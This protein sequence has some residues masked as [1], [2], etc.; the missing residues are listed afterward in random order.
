MCRNRQ[1]ALL[2]LAGTVAMI[3]L[4]VACA[5]PPQ[6]RDLNEDAVTFVS[7]GNLNEEE[8]AMMAAEAERACRTH[9]RVPVQVTPAYAGSC[10]TPV[11]GGLFGLL[12]PGCKDDI[13][14]HV[15]ACVLPE[16]NEN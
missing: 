11:D 6:L 10:E 9:G 7:Q 14:R 1:R 15:F 12:G 5:T 4:V 2:Y 3:V 16:S 13:R 8:H